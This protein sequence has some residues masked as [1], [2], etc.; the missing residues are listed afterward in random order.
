M[1]FRI[2]I[3]ITLLLALAGSGWFLV[4]KDHFSLPYKD[5][6][7]QHDALGWIVMG[8]NW[9][10]IGDAVVNR[11]DEHGA[12]LVTG[13]SD[14]SNV[15]LDVDLKLIGHAGDVG[16]MV[17]V[18]D[19]EPGADAYNGYYVGLRSDDRA[20]VM[21]RADY[22]WMEGYP[23][24]LIGGVIAGRW[25]HLH[26]VAVGCAIGAEAID[27]ITGA[28]TYGFLEERNCV[29]KGKIGLR[30]MAT[31]GE[32]SQVVVKEASPSELAAI[33]SKVTFIQ[34]PR[35][36]FRSADSSRFL[37]EAADQESQ[38]SSEI[39]RAS[40][41]V[42]NI[43]TLKMRGSGMQE[44]A[45]IRGFVTLLNPLYVQDSTGGIAVDAPDQFV[46]NLGDEVEV[47]GSTR[48]E[49]EK[50]RFVAK[51]VKLT[52]DRTLVPPSSVTSTQA[53]GILFDGRLA[54]LRARLLSKKV[55]SEGRVTLQ[56]ED[57]AQI[58]RAEG[59]G[60]LSDEQFQNLVPGS[61]L[62]IRGV[63]RVGPWQGKEG[64]A[65]TILM[66]SMEDVEI[67]A[68]PPWWS[69]RLLIRE[70]ALLVILVGLGIYIYLKAERSK[71]RAILHERER[72][73]HE[74]H[75]TLAQSFAGLGF[76]LQG[77]RNSVRSGTLTVPAVVDKLT[78][79]CDL[80]TRTHRDASAEI[81]ALHP[82]TDDGSDLLT[83]LERCTYTMLEGNPLPI[84]L[85][86][87]GTPHT[88]S[89]AVRDALFHV[90]REAITNILRHAQATS[91]TMRTKYEFR[92]VTLEICDDG[93]GFDYER[94]AK[95][96][97]F[98]GIHTRSAAIGATVEIISEIDWGTC[99]RVKAPY[100]MRRTVAR[101]IRLERA[102]STDRI[103]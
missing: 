62:R 63:C 28:T 56:L 20:L 79:A 85:I 21:G 77:V 11:S 18:N 57:S 95:G 52:G 31:G 24:E 27:K 36:V 51:Y 15:A 44:V 2:P 55:D 102:S 12:K 50:V 42:S 66:R 101:R 54:E 100:R 39:R 7:A 69:T 35:F 61:E 13:S 60:G 67:V 29:A 72:L 76:H 98:C 99:V 80:V 53:A 73:A 70:V 75:D 9:Q 71:M 84:E 38:P 16:V 83:L 40:P 68:G 8:G 92:F 22:G 78:L 59:P 14:W 89:L 17:R 19:A 82:G 33:K 74:M 96:F 3:V 34:K 58:F 64:G 48:N 94:H 1:K 30:S 6:F 87:E 10:F 4:R 49:D 23:T 93:C 41:I 86:R 88:L 65:F 37:G 103:G 25:Y 32:W 26:V 46:L 81:A 97:G 91:I 43:E 5:H 45:T 90:G 47:V